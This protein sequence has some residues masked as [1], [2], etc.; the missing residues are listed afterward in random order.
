[1]WLEFCWTDFR[2]IYSNFKFNDNPSSGSRVVPC[3]R[4]DVTKLTVA[5]RNFAE[6]A[7]KRKAVDFRFNYRAGRLCFAIST[8]NVA[9]YNVVNKLCAM[10]WQ[11]HAVWRSVHCVSWLSRCL[12]SWPVIAAALATLAINVLYIARPLTQFDTA[13][14]YPAAAVCSLTCVVMQHDH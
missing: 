4:T 1:M 2:K 10:C 8:D 7:W 3:G 6:S 11:S 13:P 5:F 14:Y 12:A 9:S